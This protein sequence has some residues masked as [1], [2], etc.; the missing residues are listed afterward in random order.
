MNTKKLTLIVFLTLLCLSMFSCDHD[1]DKEINK[2]Y[3]ELQATG[4]DEINGSRL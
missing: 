2:N 3:G 4:K 1:D